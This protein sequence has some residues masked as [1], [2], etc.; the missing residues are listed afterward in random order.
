MA[1]R[2]I[3]N[4]TVFGDD[5]VN[6]PRHYT[7]GQFEVI[8]VIEDTLSAEAFQ[9]YCEGNILKYIMRHRRKGGLEDLLKA[10][11]Y[12]NRMIERWPNLEKQAEQTD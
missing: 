6:H 8:D 2:T 10:R 11:W 9:G 7:Y 3:M 12:L 4:P 5:T 1:N